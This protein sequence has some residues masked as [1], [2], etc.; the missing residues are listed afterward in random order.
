MSVSWLISSVLSS[1]LL[2][3]LNGLLPVIAGL[4]LIRTRPRLARVLIA[5]GCLLLV[6]LSLG[7]VA[8]GLTIPLERAYPPL[9]LKAVARQDPG[10]I[11]VLGGGRYRDA[12]EFG[13][14]DVAGAALERVRYGAFL[15]RELGKPLLVTGGAPEG[16]GIPEGTLMARA[17][18][19]DFGIRVRWIEA[20][21]DNTFENARNSTIVLR[22]A[23]VT[24][25]AL[26]THA[27]HM[28]RAVAAFRGAGLDVLAAPTA[29][30]TSGPL[31]HLDFLP[32]APAMQASAR[33][34]HEWIGMAWYRVRH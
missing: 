23:G 30:A 33:A 14:D 12:P 16:G 29:F 22:N 5:G 15:A 6:V 4:L 3:P 17:L 9:D 24:R 20:A 18:E 10:A 32:R 27:W 1:M 8:R 26:V 13:D 25:I 19:R 34:L 31:T 2:P 28:P 21:S 11:V 7:V